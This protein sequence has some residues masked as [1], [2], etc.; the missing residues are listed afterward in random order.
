MESKW[1]Y[2]GYISLDIYKN[3]FPNFVRVIVQSCTMDNSNAQYIRC[4]WFDSLN[5]SHIANS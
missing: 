1:Q 4:V 2:G 3:V 5:Y